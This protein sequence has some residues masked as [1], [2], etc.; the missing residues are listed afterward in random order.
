MPLTAETRHLIG[1]RE[2]SLIKPDTVLINTS[3]GEVVDQ[4]AVLQEL[5]DGNLAGA[6]LD[7][8]ATEPPDISDPLFSLPTVTLSPHVAGSS[9]ENIESMGDQARTVFDAILAGRKP[10]GLIN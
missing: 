10:V 2:L 6:G 8:F 5:V 3:R 7:V 9:K 4:L 1:G